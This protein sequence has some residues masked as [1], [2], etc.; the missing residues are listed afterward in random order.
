MVF[1]WAITAPDADPLISAHDRQQAQQQAPSG[2]TWG[3]DITR[4]MVGPRVAAARFL[5]LPGWLQR[6]DWFAADDQ[7]LND[8]V[9]ATTTHTDGITQCLGVSLAGALGLKPGE[10]GITAL[11][12]LLALAGARLESRRVRTGP[13]RDSEREYVYRVV[14]DPLAWRPKKDKPPLTDPITPDQVVAAWSAAL[15]AAGVPK[16]P[17]LDR[18]SGFGTG[19]REQTTSTRQPVAA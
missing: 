6:S 13:G 19:D 3:P 12:Q 16:N 14:V 5:D 15:D 7:A 11:R 9:T 18:C 2:Q 1:R 4:A 10:R 17:L 8:L